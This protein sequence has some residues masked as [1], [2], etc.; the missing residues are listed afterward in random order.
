MNKHVATITD[1]NFETD[2]LQ[3]SKPVLVDYS[4][5]WCGPCRALEPAVDQIAERFEGRVVVGKVDV[6]E[7]QRTASKYG[8]RGVPTLMLFKDG[9]VVATRVGAM[10]AAQLAS[11]VENNI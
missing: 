2:V 4:A 7:N 1:A 10:S 5:T 9:A 8:V 6:D 11:F 3:A